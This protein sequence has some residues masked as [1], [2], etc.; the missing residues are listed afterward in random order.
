MTHLMAIN[1]TSLYAAK[2]RDEEKNIPTLF[3]LKNKSFNP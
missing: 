2:N 1:V 3:V